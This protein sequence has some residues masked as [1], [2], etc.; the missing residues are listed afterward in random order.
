MTQPPVDEDPV[1]RI[2]DDDDGD[3]EALAFMLESSGWK[4]QAYS[5]ARDFLVNDAPSQPGCVVL[6]VR[7]PGMTGLELQEEMNRRGFR[8]PIIFLTAH[9][10]VAMAVGAMQKGAV[11]FLLKP[12]D[13]AAFARAVSQAVQLQGRIQNDALAPG[14]CI[15]RF[16]SL[17]ERQQEIVSMIADGFLNREVAVKLGISERTVEGHRYNAFKLLGVKNRSELARFLSR[18]RKIRR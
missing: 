16:E 3:R 11:N 2:V 12:I 18:V 17:S 14:E 1:V 7:M 6:D 8:L 10:D 5:S 9:G 4:V 15:A 13:P